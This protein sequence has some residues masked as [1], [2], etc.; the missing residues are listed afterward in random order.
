[1]AHVTLEIPDE[2][3]ALLR[4]AAAARGVAEGAVAAEAIALFTRHEHDME[5]RIAEGRADIAAG[6]SVDHAE[7]RRWLRS[8][9]TEEALPPP[10]CD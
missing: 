8:W 5:Q 7:V 3:A 2:V 10:T 6:R 1:M 4:E 9:G